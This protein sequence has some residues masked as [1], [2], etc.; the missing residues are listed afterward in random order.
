MKRNRS[1]YI[2]F[3]LILLVGCA[4]QGTITTTKPDALKNPF[5]VQSYK[6]LFSIAQTYN[7]AWLTFKD[8]HTAKIIS[9]SDFETGKAIAREYRTAHQEAVSALIKLEKGEL[10]QLQTEI[11]IN[12]A[13]EANK[14]I[15]VYL[16]PSIRK[17]GD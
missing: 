10:G 1:V 16:Q 9:D 12:L 11:M 13:L 3:A 17:K 15:L 4:S 14:K 5:V 7:A 2:F 8:L 6:T